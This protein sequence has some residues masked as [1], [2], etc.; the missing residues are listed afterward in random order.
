MFLYG[1]HI[2]E[3]DLTI[4]VIKSLVH[5]VFVPLCALYYIAFS[6]EKQ[7]KEGKIY[8]IC[9]SQKRED[10]DKGFIRWF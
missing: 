4:G 5:K 6:L 1:G 9:E 2:I 7:Y 10:L 3:N 8:G